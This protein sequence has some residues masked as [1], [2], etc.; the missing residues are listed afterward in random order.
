MFDCL[1]QYPSA[2]CELQIENKNWKPSAKCE[3]VSKN[4][5]EEV[6]GRG[7]QYTNRTASNPN[8]SM[9]TKQ[10][11]KRKKCKRM[12]YRW[13]HTIRRRPVTAKH[14]HNKHE[15]TISVRC[16]SQLVAHMRSHLSVWLMAYESICLCVFAPNVLNCTSMIY[17][18]L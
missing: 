1:K 18:I 11:D 9:K 17:N 3:Y 4:N 14:N 6:V 12:L 16:V 10:K 7:T 2:L 13:T 8:K 5:R 15:R